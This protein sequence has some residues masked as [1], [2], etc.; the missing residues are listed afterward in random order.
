MLYLL[1]MVIF[2]GYVSHN[3]RVDVSSYFNPGDFCD[4]NWRFPAMPWLDLETVPGI[5]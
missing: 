4:K 3:Q 2:H 5:Q 1:K